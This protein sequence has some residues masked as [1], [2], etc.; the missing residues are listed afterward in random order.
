[1]AYAF[2]LRANRAQVPHFGSVL[3]AKPSSD[4]IVIRALALGEFSAADSK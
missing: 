4:R 3:T 1:M 2:G